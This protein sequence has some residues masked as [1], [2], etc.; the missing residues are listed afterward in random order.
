MAILWETSMS[1]IPI[2]RILW[3]FGNKTLIIPS[4]I[5]IWERGFIS[6][7]VVKSCLQASLKLDTL[8][9]WCDYPYAG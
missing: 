5:V 9:A 4:I 7:N 2:C 3:N 6:Q 1:G 8:D